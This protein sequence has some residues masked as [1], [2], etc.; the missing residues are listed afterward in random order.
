MWSRKNMEDR[1]QWHTMGTSHA[2]VA[3][4]T[5]PSPGPSATSAANGLT[6]H[7][8]A[9]MPYLGVLVCNQPEHQ[10]PHLPTPVRSTDA[11]H[12]RARVE[13]HADRAAAGSAYRH[14]LIVAVQARHQERQVT[15]GRLPHHLGLVRGQLHRARSNAGT[16]IGCEQSG[17]V[18]RGWR[19]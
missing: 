1:V 8:M 5:Y 4:T 9:D 10:V 2:C 15:A 6:R 14:L 13:T 18:Q 12:Q 19:C 11:S 17:E 3:S 16:Q 7:G